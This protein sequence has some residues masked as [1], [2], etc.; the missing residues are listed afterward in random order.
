MKYSDQL[1]YTNKK[2]PKKNTSQNYF[3]IMKMKNSY[4]K[5]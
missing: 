1:L 4:Y 3:F 5:I 2:L